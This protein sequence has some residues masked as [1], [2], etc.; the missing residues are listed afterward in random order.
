M[1]KIFYTLLVMLM[2]LFTCCT[3]S[4]DD[5]INDINIKGPQTEVYINN[6][7]I[8][9]TRAAGYDTPVQYNGE[10]A[11][12]V[13]YF[14]RIDDNIPGE[15]NIN[16]P[17]DQYFPMTSAKKSMLCNDNKGYVKYD[18]DWKSNEIK[19]FPKYVYS[20]DG[21]VV[22]SLILKQPTLEDLVNADKG[23]GNDFT[24]YLEHKDELHF[25]WYTCKQQ[26][27][28]KKWHI[29]GILTS[30]DRTDVS[31]TKYA[32]EFGDI[33]V[34]IHQQEHKDWNETKTSVHVRKATDVTIELPIGID[35]VCPSDDFAIRTFEEFIPGQKLDEKIVV[36][37]SHEETKTVI[38]ITGITQAVLDKYNGEVTVEVHNYFTEQD[39]WDKLKLST[40]T[41]SEYKIKVIGQITSAFNDEVI[42]L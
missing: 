14:I 20:S 19:G 34:D 16:L 6:S 22:E 37:V 2:C 3:G 7:K 21:S 33:E 24:G 17:A 42:K 25:I 27:V 30:N 8:V 9:A 32:D 31:Q 23:P 11:Y 4:N 10:D 36:T 5:F 13:W 28:D 12:E 1:K 38:H 18:F 41:T 35:L 29:D 39:F 40:V 15:D 26:K